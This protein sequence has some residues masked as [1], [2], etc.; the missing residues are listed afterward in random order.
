MEVVTANGI[1]VVAGSALFTYS[2]LTRDDQKVC[3]EQN[4]AALYALSAGLILFGLHAAAVTY[5]A[6]GEK[7]ISTASL[8]IF[9]LAGTGLGLLLLLTE[10][11][12]RK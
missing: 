6:T 12:R 1:F 10:T 9:F 3:H 5:Y 4:P 2:I 11:G 7:F 8:M